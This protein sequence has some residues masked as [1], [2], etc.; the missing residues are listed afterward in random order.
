MKKTLLFLFFS[1]IA[2][3]SAFSQTASE[4]S[5]L[6]I[7][8]RERPQTAESSIYK[9]IPF[10]KIEPTDA[11][12]IRPDFKEWMDE[13]RYRL[14]GTTQITD[15]SLKSESESAS[16]SNLKNIRSSVIPEYQIKTPF[17]QKTTAAFVDHTTDFV[18]TIQIIDKE[19]ILVDEHIQLITTQERP[20]ERILSTTVNQIPQSTPLFID[21]IS[22]EKDNKPVFVSTTQAENQLLITDN[23]K[24]PP[25]VHNIRLKYLVKNALQPF[26]GAWRLAISL[27]GSNWPLPIDRF[28]LITL[29]PQQTTLFSKE[30]LFGTNNQP[31]INSFEAQ[32]DS[33]SNTVYTLTRPLPAFADVKVVE[34]FDGSQLLSPPFEA[35]IKTALPF[36]IPILCFC[37]TLLY[38]SVSFFYLKWKK[39]DKNILK[40]IGNS[41]FFVLCFIRKKNISQSLLDN[42]ITYH[43]HQKKKSRTLFLLKSLLRIKFVGYS[44]QKTLNFCAFAILSFKYLITEILFILITFYWA[45]EKEVQISHMTLLFLI[46]GI[47]VAHLIFFKRA[48]IPALKKDISLFSQ[49][50]LNPDIGFGLSNQAVTAL[51]LRYYCASISLDIH[52]KWAT[53]IRKTCPSFSPLVNKGE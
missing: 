11:E 6:D 46:I 50:L 13:E 18:V 51:Y 36:L 7:R 35:R 10:V 9:G 25:G 48:L 14:F 52:S 26:D 29:Q 30:L 4:T 8:N 49:R 3:S 31:I 41:P 42:L 12:N 39:N 22:V 2:A 38:L 21:L 28:S 15:K 27:T 24:M 33:K 17:G 47:I 16:I 43:Q 45:S 40:T 5:L 19:T 53:I 23:T 37:I 44:V 20:F 34:M 32:T 1:F